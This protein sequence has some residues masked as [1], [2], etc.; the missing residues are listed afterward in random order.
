MLPTS[1]PKKKKT[2]V[3]GMATRCSRRQ[4]NIKE[5]PDEIG[6]DL[7]VTLPVF[8]V[9]APV[10]SPKYRDH[11]ELTRQGVVNV[12]SYWLASQRT[13]WHDARICLGGTRTNTLNCF[14]LC[15][16]FKMLCQAE[17]GGTRQL[18][19]A[20]KNYAQNYAYTAGIHQNRRIPYERA[21]RNLTVLMFS[22]LVH[23]LENSRSNEGHRTLIVQECL[24]VVGA[25]GRYHR[26]QCR[27]NLQE[28][29][30]TDWNKI[31]TRGL[32]STHSG[33][34]TALMMRRRRRWR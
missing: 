30:S 13:C 5:I 11:D 17:Y 10:S 8:M 27:T 21:L 32:H 18:H 9:M 2:L 7:L 23:Q 33:K 6:G 19:L 29:S 24:Q 22:H 3:P 15:Y 25:L 31:P 1:L 28:A 20:A 14:D 34:G 4:N 12:I 16:S 26:W